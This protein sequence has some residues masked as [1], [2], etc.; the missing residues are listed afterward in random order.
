MKC[1][2]AEDTLDKYSP[3]TVR[4]QRQAH[5][6]DNMAHSLHNDIDMLLMTAIILSPQRETDTFAPVQDLK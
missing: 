3:H 4:M 1:Q 2:E 6:D 5:L